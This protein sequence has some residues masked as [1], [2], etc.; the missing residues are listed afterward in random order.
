MILFHWITHWVSNV[1]KPRHIL[2]MQSS[3]RKC[4][5]SV[6]RQIPREFIPNHRS[7]LRFPSWFVNCILFILIYYLFS[8]Q[9]SDLWVFLFNF[10]ASFNEKNLRKTICERGGD[11]LHMCFSQS[12]KYDYGSEGTKV[13]KKKYNTLNSTGTASNVWVGYSSENS[14]KKNGWKRERVEQEKYEK[15]VYCT[16]YVVWLLLLK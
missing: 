3:Y 7:I 13:D 11:W 9:I 14:E 2:E 5:F 12:R 10:I 15:R 6:P 8:F 16:F 1:Q 4:L